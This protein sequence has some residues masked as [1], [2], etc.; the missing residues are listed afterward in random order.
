MI[1]FFFYTQ[2]THRNKQKLFCTV[3]VFIEKL[4]KNKLK[5]IMQ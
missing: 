5:K 2:P 4:R 3:L 1:I